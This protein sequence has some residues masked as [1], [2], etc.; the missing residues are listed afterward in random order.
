MSLVEAKGVGYSYQEAGTDEPAL[1]NIDLT[2]E[3]GEFVAIIGSNGS[4]KSTLARLLNVLLVPTEGEILIDGLKTSE[5]ENIWE[6]RQKVGIVFQNPDNQLVATT[7]ENDVAFGLENLGV[8]SREI[9]LRVDNALKMVGMNGFQEHETHKLSGGQK[10][11]V[12]IAGVIAMESDCIVLDEPTAM[13]DP[14]GRKEVMDTVTYL[15]KEKGITII[16]ITHFMEEAA[17]ADKIYVM[18]QGQIYKS[19]TPRDIFQ[20]VEGLK[21]VNLDVP[22]VVELANNLRK[23]GMTVPRILSIDELVSCLC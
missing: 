3:S 5:K 9:R 18:H 19:G 4:G 6:I 11:R 17:L 7:V 2:V 22:Q 14:R 20:D 23:A 16:H 1:K 15:N 12:A 10:Q 13:L 21:S 8:P